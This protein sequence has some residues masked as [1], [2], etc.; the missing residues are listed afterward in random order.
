MFSNNIEPGICLKVIDVLSD[1]ELNISWNW[2][3]LKD[4]FLMSVSMK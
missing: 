1:Y 3:C 2:V 4:D